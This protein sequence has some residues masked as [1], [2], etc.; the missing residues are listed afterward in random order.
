MHQQ[1]SAYS[2]HCHRGT[3]TSD[4]QQD[5]SYDEGEEE[6]EETEEIYG[7]A[8]EADRAVWV[9]KVF[10]EANFRT[11]QLIF[12]RKQG[13]TITRLRQPRDL[14]ALSSA[15]SQV[16]PRW[17]AEIQVLQERPDHILYTP[18]Q[19]EPLGNTSQI[20]TVPQR[21]SDFFGKVVY[22][23]SPDPEIKYFCTSKVG[24][25]A[26][27]P[28]PYY[29]PQG[30]DDKTLV[31][32]SRF[33][34][35]N[36][37]RAIKVG[38][39]D[40]ELWLRFDLYTK[41]HT[42]WYYFKVQNARANVQYRFTIMNF[43]KSGSLYNE[44]MKPLM[45]SAQ[46][47][48]NGIGWLR[49]GNN[50]KYYRNDIKVDENKERCYYSL[51]W[52]CSFPNDN[53]TYYFAHSYPFTYSDLQEYLTYLDKDVKRR[54][55]CKQRILCRTL[56]G[57]HLYILTV[58]NPARSP[59]EASLKKY[60][61]ITA[62]VHPG[63]TV[64]SWMMKGFLDFL[65]SEQTEAISLRNQY[66][67]KV[68]PMLNPDG[69]IVGNYRCSLSG[70]DLNRNYK[71]VLRESFPTVW[72]TRGLIKKLLGQKKIVIYCDLHGHS[73][74]KNIFIY[75]CQNKMERNLDTKLFSRVYPMLLS[76]R[77]PEVFSFD[78]CRF[79]VQR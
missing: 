45:Y 70:R 63:E 37:M 62:R 22:D 7:P 54:R 51:T 1:D 61:V 68:I 23:N 72:N 33:E 25:K 55:C 71:T 20:V 27:S 21:S 64:S 16:M 15:P 60:V 3:A 31:F 66:I 46:N 36:L 6:E 77:C 74:K 47:A 38:E 2:S 28:R 73:R 17:P 48:K 8:I 34:S 67:F 42:Q 32:E 11:T 13:K 65:T 79:K 14:Y 30:I 53:D 12:K 76:K 10:E 57:N 44:G 4:E 58:T 56:A 26:I 9:P 43:L 69:V 24:G 75:G 40:Y 19:R 41:K 29:V 52:T 59:K 35:G 39:R 78:D 49:V 18:Y 50:I 5:I